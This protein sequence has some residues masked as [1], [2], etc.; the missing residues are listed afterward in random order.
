MSRLEG[1]EEKGKQKQEGLH[2]SNGSV[3]LSVHIDQ[4]LCCGFFEERTKDRTEIMANLH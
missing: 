3:S 1:E 4:F 2:S